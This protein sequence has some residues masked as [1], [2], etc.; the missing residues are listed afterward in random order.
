M[1]NFPR[2]SAD[3]LIWWDFLAP[4]CD[5]QGLLSAYDYRINGSG[6]NLRLSLTYNSEGKAQAVTISEH[7]GDGAQ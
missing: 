7:A 6:L 5:L 3:L 4:E 2:I 1:E